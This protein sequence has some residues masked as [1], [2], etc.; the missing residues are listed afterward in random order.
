MGGDCMM[1]MTPVVSY[2][3]G[4]CFARVCP[5]CGR[6]VI[7]DAEVTVYGPADEPHYREGLHTNA[8]CSR[9]G[10]VEMPFQ[11]HA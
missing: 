3:G 1:D 6:W 7:A 9:C 4:A 11:G 5:T 10:R 2:M 8:T